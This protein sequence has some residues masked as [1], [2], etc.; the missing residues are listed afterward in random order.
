PAQNNTRTRAVT[1]TLNP[2]PSSS[3]L[4]FNSEAKIFAGL[5]QGKSSIVVKSSFV[6]KDLSSLS[7]NILLVVRGC[8]KAY[9]PSCIKRDESFF[10]AK[11][12]C[13]CGMLQYI[14][15]LFI[16]HQIFVSFC[17]QSGNDSCVLS[18]S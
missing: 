11:A 14:K 4:A 15:S 16:F 7:I 18:F 13:N 5:Q 10:K 3:S 6:F 8:P 9:H 1:A 2:K 17:R 12:K